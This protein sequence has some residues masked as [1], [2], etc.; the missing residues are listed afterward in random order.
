MADDYIGTLDASIKAGVSQGFIRRLVREGRIE[1]KK[2]GRDWILK[3]ES[4]EDYLKSSKGK[5]GRKPLDKR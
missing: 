3:P 4:L 1:G 2:I 5:P